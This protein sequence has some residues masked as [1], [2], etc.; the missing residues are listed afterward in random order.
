[1][2]GTSTPSPNKLLGLEALRFLAAFAVLIWHY[3]HFAYVAD[4][5]VGLVREQLP[6]YGLLQ[7]FYLAGEYGV[8]VFWCIS[9]FIFF[10]KYRDAI[11]DGSMPGWTNTW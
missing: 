10:W 11:S 3:Q 5:P 2:P 4:T 6:F 9:G 1:M 7:L 8:W